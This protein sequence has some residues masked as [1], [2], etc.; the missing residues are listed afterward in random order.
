MTTA[1]ISH[2]YA[3]CYIS[4]GTGCTASH[5]NGN[6]GRVVIGPDQKIVARAN[7][8]PT[9]RLRFLLGPP[10]LLFSSAARAMADLALPAAVLSYNHRWHD[11]LG[12]G[13]IGA[14][15]F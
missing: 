13:H 6:S 4:S 5:F 11:E 15:E 14:T 1:P 2:S 10:I 7:I 3:T 8:S 9:M 12:T